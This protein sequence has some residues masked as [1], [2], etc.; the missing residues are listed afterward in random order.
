MPDITKLRASGTVR[1]TAAGN[2]SA[3]GFAPK[4]IIEPIQEGLGRE[5]PIIV[6]ASRLL[7]LG[8]KSRFG[9]RVLDKTPIFWELLRLAD[10]QG[11]AQLHKLLPSDG[12]LFEELIAGVH[13]EL[14]ARVVDL[15]PASGD[16]GV[17]VWATY[18]IEGAGKVTLMDQVK[19]YAPG[20]DINPGDIQRILSAHG[21]GQEYSKAVLT[22]TGR[23]PEVARNEVR[24]FGERVILRDR[25]VL[26][27]VFERV[28]RNSLEE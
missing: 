20:N 5:L 26:G 21:R 13:S 7:V 24:V 10:E 2:L 17:D 1:I 14:G 18:E 12:R 4:A 9:E 3:R 27:D 25:D 15:S 19:L 23:I 11:V 8:G 28:L 6:H 16:G 22:T